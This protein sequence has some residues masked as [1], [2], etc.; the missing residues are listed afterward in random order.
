[1]DKNKT[2]K[3]NMKKVYFSKKNHIIGFS[4]GK[5]S[6][7][8]LE[9]LCEMIEE[10]PKEQ[11]TNKIH[12][13]CSDTGVETPEMTA[14]QYRCIDSL[15]TYAAKSSL[16]FEVHMVRP[17]IKSRFFY[18][19]LGR[20]TNVPVGNVR[21]R[22]CTSH[23]KL[24]PMQ[25][26]LQKLIS[27]MPIDLGNLKDEHDVYLWLGVR[28][29]ESS[30][31]KRSIQDLELSASSYFAKHPDTPRIMYF[32]P[33]KFLPSDEVF[34][35]LMSREQ[36]RYGIRTEELTIQ[37]GEEML[38]CGIKT[39]E[40]DI[41]AA[42]SSNG[43]RSGC[44]V[45]P[46]VTEDKMLKRLISEG[47]TNY[48]FL[49][50]WKKLVIAMRNDI[51]YRTI[52]PRKIYNKILKKSNKTEDQI[53]IFHLESENEQ[54]L[55]NYSIFDRVID[56]GYIPGALS[57][58]GRKILLEYLLYIQEQSG[59]TLIEEDEIKAILDSWIETDGVQV[60]R[61]E[62]SPKKYTYDGEVV[63]LPDM[64]LNKAKTKNSNPIFYVE[65]DFNLG[66][67]KLYQ[68]LKERQQVTHKNYFCFPSSYDNVDYQIVWNKAKFIVCSKD[69]QTSNHAHEEI[70]RWLG[71]NIQPHTMNTET[72]N[73][74]ISHIIL[75]ALREGLSKDSLDNQLH[76]LTQINYGEA[77]DGQLLLDF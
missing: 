11:R 71:W 30:R 18:K 23:L 77:I 6:S 37:Y 8:L 55:H 58:E 19:L 10:L 60:T 7:F 52:R 44:W 40:G 51:R 15:R 12:I 4:G 62:I 41:G 56:E 39:S 43:A 57:I 75:N 59:Y 49:L 53:N 26:K 76:H 36:L 28:N 20:G 5:D 38:E 3:E 31:R 64:T 69:I 50:E 73:R 14:Y 54:N 32:H 9:M 42:C 65:V 48:T 16:P 74:G 21:N 24:L 33:I 17:P 1:M 25:K 63:V 72:Y 2:I 35:E 66:E 67:G 34:F 13:I 27:K 46:L 61:Q 68:L 29:E 22:W 47:Q 45:C 70:F